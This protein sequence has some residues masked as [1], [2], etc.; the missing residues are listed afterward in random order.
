MMFHPTPLKD[1]YLIEL[2]RRADDRGFF[3]RLFC[4]NE[5]AEAGLSPQF[6]QI[7]NAF[8]TKKATLRGLH[9][10][11]PPSAEIKLVRCVRG[12]LFDCIIDIRP[13]SPTYEKW[14]GAELDENN[15]LAMY[16]PRGFAH[17][18]LTLKTDTEVLYMVSD[19]YTPERERGLRWD[20]PHFNVSWP[21]KPQE[22]SP[23]DLAWPDFDP[24]F[25]GVERLRGIR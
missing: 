7:N 15:R 6:V 12:A 5:F 22:I 9:Y 18:I 19:F 20:D 11:L 8:S 24:T 23:K 21:F 3:A 17:G 25:H 10:Q 1:A 14:F 2:E 16:V 13:D 4:Q